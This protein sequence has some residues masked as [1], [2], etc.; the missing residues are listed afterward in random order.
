M[1]IPSQSEEKSTPKAFP[2]PSHNP[3]VITRAQVEFVGYGLHIFVVIE[4]K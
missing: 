4:L 2:S 1:A 3:S